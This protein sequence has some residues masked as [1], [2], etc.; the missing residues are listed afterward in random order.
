MSCACRLINYTLTTEENVGNVL[1]CALSNYL[2]MHSTTTPNQTILNVRTRYMY[3]SQRDFFRKN[4][5]DFTDLHMKKINLEV[6][7]KRNCF[8]Y[9]LFLVYCR[10][11]ALGTVSLTGDRAQGGDS[12][13]DSHYTRICENDYQI[14]LTWQPHMYFLP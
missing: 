11:L 7:C 1:V 8:G 10:E 6:S 14:L 2:E 4:I 5:G 13:H 9:N 3:I 12:K